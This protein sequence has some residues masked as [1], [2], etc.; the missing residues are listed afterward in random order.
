MPALLP[1]WLACLLAISIVGVLVAI[2]IGYPLATHQEYRGPLKALPPAPRLQTAPARDLQDYQ[3]AKAQ[4]L[5]GSRGGV[6]ITEAMK[7]TARQGWG[8]P[9]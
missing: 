5:K 4:E 2:S 7:Q 3:A 8:P 6:P 9:K 1:F